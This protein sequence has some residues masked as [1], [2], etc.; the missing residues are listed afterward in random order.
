MLEDTEMME[1][2]FGTPDGSMGAQRQK[3]LY[4]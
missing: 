4:S 2:D 3:T 1:M